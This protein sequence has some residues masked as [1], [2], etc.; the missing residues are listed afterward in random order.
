MPKRGQGNMTSRR[1]WQWQE[2][3]TVIPTSEDSKMI[4]L[5]TPPVDFT[6]LPPMSSDEHF[7]LS[8][9]K[10]KKVAGSPNGSR[11]GWV[12]NFAIYPYCNPRNR[13]PGLARELNPFNLEPKNR[14]I[15]DFQI[16][17]P[18]LHFSFRRPS[19]FR[20]WVKVD[21]SNEDPGARSQGVPGRD[22][23]NGA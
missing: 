18:S 3:E 9:K 16:I 8:R 14:T 20:D 13:V 12:R 19:R 11:S 5:P 1:F 22:H 23:S 17:Y 2:Q 6:V 15:V 10:K 21:E 4:V 7:F